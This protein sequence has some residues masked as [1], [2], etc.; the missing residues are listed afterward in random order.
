M[1]KN[2]ITKALVITTGIL[3]SFSSFAG[4]NIYSND[5]LLTEKAVKNGTYSFA[6]EGLSP[7][8]THI[9]NATVINMPLKM[10]LDN[11]VPDG[12]RII[13]NKEA[14]E[15]LVSFNGG[16]AWP[17]VL[18]RMSIDHQLNSHIDWKYKIVNVFSTKAREKFISDKR[19]DLIKRH[20]QQV[21]YLK[22]R[23][24]EKRAELDRQ[25]AIQDSHIDL[26]T[27]DNDKYQKIMN[28]LNGTNSSIE[29]TKNINS[30]KPML[31][32]KADNVDVSNGTKTQKDTM[33]DSSKENNNIKNSSEKENGVNENKS[34]VDNSK[35]Q[36]ELVDSNL[37]KNN[38]MNNGNLSQKEEY[39]DY[40]ENK[41]LEDNYPYHKLIDGAPYK[42]TIQQKD[43]LWKLSDHFL[44]NPWFWPEIWHINLDDIENPHLIY[45]GEIIVIDPSKPNIE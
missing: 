28:D 17:Y 35:K 1:K 30:T 27:E 40:I 16:Q 39:A 31:N 36:K 44:N 42:Y 34:L 45:P 23:I 41:T 7:E 2:K 13:I 25:K 37:N 3:A 24:K 26:K 38:S 10:S 8:K 4:L 20:N 19:E 32:N 21:A 22:N 33:M 14:E 11:V 29:S 18:E 6:Q 43:T 15:Q 9:V 12:W 5:V